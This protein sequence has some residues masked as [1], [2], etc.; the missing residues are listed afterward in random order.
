MTTEKQ[1]GQMFGALLLTAM[2]LGLWNNFGLTNPIY[3]GAGWL[4]NGA[5]MPMLFGASALLGLVTSAITLAAAIIA[6]PVLRQSTPSLAL[7]F[8]LLT[9]V[10]FATSTMEQANFLSLRSL[11]LQYIKHPG[12]DPA[13]FE[14][15][16]SMVVANRNWIHYLDKIIGG[17]SLLVLYVALYRSNRVPRVIPLVGM[18][19]API[20][21]GGIALELF[22]L[23]LP[24][25][26]LAPLAL[27][28]FVLC[29]TLLVRG[30]ARPAPARASAVAA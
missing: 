14:V 1:T 2:L 13:L 6:W 20:Q 29:L 30:F 26:M 21:M 18:L 17:G 8:L 11:S 9:V 22:L 3:S 24:M 7:A 28:Q 23:K 4:Q 12:L 16:R 27:T 5:Q 19:A 10:G 15:L 25:A